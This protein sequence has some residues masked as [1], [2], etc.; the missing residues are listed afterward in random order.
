M[1]LLPLQNIDRQQFQELPGL[2]P[3]VFQYK[4][5]LD[6][7]VIHP[8]EFCPTKSAQPLL[9]QSHCCEEE[10]EQALG[11]L[12]G[13]GALFYI[14]K[15]GGEAQRL[16]AIFFRDRPQQQATFLNIYCR[17]CISSDGGSFLLPA[18]ATR[19]LYVFLPIQQHKAGRSSLLGCDGMDIRI[20][21]WPPHQLQSHVI[22]IGVLDW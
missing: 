6:S 16:W 21:Q 2:L 5:S 4:D 17:A 18:G 8:Y 10:R 22:H 7:L 13:S 9:R 11:C 12:P 20:L 3:T 14:G 19:F 1:K 15:G